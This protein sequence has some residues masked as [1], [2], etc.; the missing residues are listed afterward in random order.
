MHAWGLLLVG[1]IM[2]SQINSGLAG[3][4]GPP[5]DHQH[6]YQQQVHQQQG[7]QRQLQRLQPA[8]DSSRSMGIPGY[9]SFPEDRQ[10][11]GGSL[12]TTVI[13][14]GL[15]YGPTLFNLAFGGEGGSSVPDKS[16]DKIDELEIKEEDP[17]STSNLISMAI[18]VALALFS[19]ATSDGIDKSDVNTTQS[20]LGI[21]ISALTGSED[22]SEVAVMAKQASEVV[23]MLISLVEALQTSFSSS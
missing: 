4:M 15:K 10:G 14:L 8:T 19:S 3:R 17:L 18:K 20:I 6:Q 5:R 1:L 12:L 2:S 16:T 21:V 7:Q 9:Y 13:S 23:N 11:D 22:P